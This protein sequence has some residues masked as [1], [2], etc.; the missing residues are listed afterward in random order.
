MPTSQEV[1]E[2]GGQKSGRIL[3]ED[4]GLLEFAKLIGLAVVI[5]MTARA[6]EDSWPL[7]RLY[8]GGLSWHG[9]TVTLPGGLLVVCGRT[10]GAHRILTSAE[11]CYHCSG[12]PQSHMQRVKPMVKYVSSVRHGLMEVRRPL[13]FM[14]GQRSA[15]C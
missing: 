14:N 8:A 7:V 12:S 11:C 5:W 4:R 9:G 6:A 15:D 2:G 10:F 3:A 1:E 13:P